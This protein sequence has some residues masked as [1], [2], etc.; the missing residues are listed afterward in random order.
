MDKQKINFIA[1]TFKILPVKYF[2]NL[3]QIFTVAMPWTLKLDIELGRGFVAKYL[4]KIIVNLS[5]FS[6]FFI[7]KS[8]KYLIFFQKQ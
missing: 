1:E 7:V 6:S 5:R 2:K 3:V 8:L 4:K